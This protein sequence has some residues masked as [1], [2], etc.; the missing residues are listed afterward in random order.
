MLKKAIAILIALTMFPV[1]CFAGGGVAKYEVNLLGKDSIIVPSEVIY[2][3]R[4]LDDS[5][6]IN[7]T[8]IDFNHDGEMDAS[9]AIKKNETSVL[10]RLSG[11]DKLTQDYAYHFIGRKYSDISFKLCQPVTGIKLNLKTLN[12]V[13]G[14]S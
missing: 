10:Q 3:I 13:V 7:N 8:R 4:E 1:S 9:V 14:S 5:P 12:M 2:S 11:A 6:L